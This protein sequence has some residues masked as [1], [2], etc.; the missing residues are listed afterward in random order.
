[1]ERLGVGIG[2]HEVAADEARGDHVVDRIAA[3]AADAEHGDPRLELANV[4][5]FQIDGH[6]LPLVSA[7]A[8]APLK[9]TGPPPAV[10]L[11]CRSFASPGPANVRKRRARA[12]PSTAAQ[13]GE[14][15]VNKG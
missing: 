3:G 7:D 8:R 6:G 15:M 14:W 11:K 12:A 5:H 1:R 13:S 9:L 4:G 2:D 10:A